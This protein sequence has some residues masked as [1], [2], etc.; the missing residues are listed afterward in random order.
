M[1]F[2]STICFILAVICLLSCSGWSFFSLVLFSWGNDFLEID[3]AN[4]EDAKKSICP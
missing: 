1:I 4:K 3:K 2:C